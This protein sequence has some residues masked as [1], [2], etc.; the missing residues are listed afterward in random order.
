MVTPLLIALCFPA[1]TLAITESE[2]IAHLDA[3]Q[4]FQDFAKSVENLSKKDLD[5]LAEFESLRWTIDN[6]M[7]EYCDSMQKYPKIHRQC[8]PKIKWASE[9]LDKKAKY[10]KETFKT[11]WYA[12]AEKLIESFNS[13]NRDL[14]SAQDDGKN[15]DPDT[16]YRKRTALQA[17][18]EE[19]C[20]KAPRENLAL[21]CRRILSLVKVQLANFEE[22]LRDG[23]FEDKPAS[24]KVYIDTDP[25]IRCFIDLPKLRDSSLAYKISD[26][27]GRYR[28]EHMTKSEYGYAINLPLSKLVESPLNNSFHLQKNFSDPKNAKG[29]ELQIGT[30][31]SCV[32]DGA[33]PPNC[34]VNSL[35]VYLTYSN[36]P[37]NEKKVSAS[38][39]IKLDSDFDLELPI[40]EMG[41][42]RFN[43]R[44]AVASKMRRGGWIYSDEAFEE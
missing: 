8:P 39:P 22:S 15:I 13:R 43:I 3:K 40:A 29:F 18:M 38:F 30:I 14:R 34:E 19:Y 31:H 5:S 10:L 11:D 24:K 16:L 25:V 28:Y 32:P 35:S 44:C 33:T 2:R 21:A 23:S 41:M 1:H 6:S 36:P 27:S 42:E 9:K 26:P 17:E 20:P 12:E 4:T 7:K 37:E